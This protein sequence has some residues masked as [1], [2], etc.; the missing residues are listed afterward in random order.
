MKKLIPYLIDFDFK[1]WNFDVWSCQNIDKQAK[2]AIFK[3]RNLSNLNSSFVKLI[4]MEF[5][6]A[7][8]VM[9][10]MALVICLPFK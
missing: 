2:N 9:V 3:H 1:V 5:F 7:V 8:V 6:M 10:N 4:C